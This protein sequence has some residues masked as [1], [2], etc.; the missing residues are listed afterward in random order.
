LYILSNYSRGGR[1]IQKL[2][3]LE[4]LVNTRVLKSPLKVLNTGNW[5]G[6]N[7]KTYLGPTEMGFTTFLS[8]RFITMAI[9]SKSTGQNSG[10]LHQCTDQNLI[11]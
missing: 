6:N 5:L 8:G 10:K 2:E 11:F 4:M 3:R 9:Y 7:S 1:E